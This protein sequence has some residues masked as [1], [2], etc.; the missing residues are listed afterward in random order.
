MEI[1]RDDA[2]DALLLAV[3]PLPTPEAV[4]ADG[5]S[6][7]PVTLR[8]RPDDRAHGRTGRGADGEVRAYMLQLTYTE[9]Q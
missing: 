5:A 8:G 6:H 2:E 1:V 3:F 9:L 7:L 4:A